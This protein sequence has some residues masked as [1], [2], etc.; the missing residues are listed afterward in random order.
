M[1]PLQGTAPSV[2]GRPRGLHSK[3]PSRLA[4]KDGEPP[5]DE[6]EDSAPGFLQYCWPA[7]FGIIMAV[8]TQQIWDKVSANYGDVGL[9]L[10][11]PFVLLLGRPEL[12]LSAEMMKS[13]P[14]LFL[15]IQFPIEG[16]L[17]SFFMSRRASFSRALAQV[18]FVHFIA[19][20]VLWL[21]STPGASHGM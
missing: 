17:I 7:I 14:Q 2:K 19:A 1:S 15:Y 5:E 8:I 18:G 12:G 20:F 4:P 9:R 3:A 21:L 11:Y 16:F 13:L 6:E 10:T